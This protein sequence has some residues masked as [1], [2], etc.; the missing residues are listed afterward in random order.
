MPDQP[1]TVTSLMSKSRIQLEFGC[2]AGVVELMKIA[3][4]AKNGI[5]FSSKWT[6]S[7]FRSRPARTCELIP[8]RTRRSRSGIRRSGDRH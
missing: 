7:S 4:S 3:R 1:P 6:G 8:I 5:E 2:E